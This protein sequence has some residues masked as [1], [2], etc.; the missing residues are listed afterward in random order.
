M[1]SLASLTAAAVLSFGAVAAN[2]ASISQDFST[3]IYLGPNMVGANVTGTV[4]QNVTGSTSSVRRSPWQ[5]T[6]GSNEADN[7][8]T[9]VSFGSSITYGFG[10]DRNVAK[11]LWGSPDSYNTLEFLLGGLVVDTVIGSDLF[12]QAQHGLGVS[13]VTF[14]NIAGG[15]FDAMRLLSQRNAFEFANL[16]A[17]DSTTPPSITAPVPLPA[18]GLLLLSGAGIMVLARRRAKT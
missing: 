1:H 11:L 17:Y 10:A 4:Y 7:A 14:T 6:G 18:G 13:T 5:G 3:P 12:P 16:L 2:A 15:S 8:Y 9:S